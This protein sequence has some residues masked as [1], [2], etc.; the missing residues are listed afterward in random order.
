MKIIFYIRLITLKCI[1]LFGL[2]GCFNVSELIVT[3]KDNMV[4][5]GQQIQLKAEKLLTKGKV[6]DVTSSEDVKWSSADESLATIDENG[7]VSA[8]ENVGVVE[9]TAVGTFRGV[10]FQDTVFIN[11]IPTE[12]ASITVTPKIESIAV[13]LSQAYTA[14]ANFLNGQ[15]LIITE[16]SAVKWSSRNSTVATVGNTEGSKGIAKANSTG[17]TIITA[18]LNI[19]GKSY[20]DEAQLNVTQSVPLSLE[21]TPKDF[22]LPVGLKKQ[23][24]ANLTMSNDSVVDIT[25]L[26]SVIWVSSDPS[27]ASVS[28][29]NPSKGE[30]E[31]YRAGTVDISAS[32]IVNGEFMY[33]ITTLDV[34]EAVITSL[35]IES[36]RKFLPEGLPTEFKVFAKLSNGKNVDMTKDDAISWSTSNSD[37]ATI[38]N[39]PLDKGTVTGHSSGR[40]I[41]TAFAE[42]D[43]VT[44]KAKESL[45]VIKSGIERLHVSSKLA[46]ESGTEQLFP[47]KNRQFIAEAILADGERVDVT[48]SDN[49]HWTSSKP[50]SASISNNKEN[51][52]LVSAV[53][54]SEAIINAKFLS[55]EIEVEGSAQ[56]IV[57]QP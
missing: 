4:P 43:G 41:V 2:T 34:T 32:A 31:A 10:E 44:F 57:V 14:T 23:Y 18:T 38:S 33:D 55:K 8:G 26:S 49:L 29:R 47:G 22:K 15:A 19:D 51:K 6:V 56:L 46:L 27:I 28:N 17:S 11:I 50:N 53:E 3:P 21:L 35:N 5:V 7:L 54:E 1:V 20:S 12:I 9:I 16:S 24:Q 13:G 42:L 48:N 40:V 25:N 30:V 36:E 37:R 52:G 45:Y 39:S